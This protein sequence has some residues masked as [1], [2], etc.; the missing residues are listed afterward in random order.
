MPEWVDWQ[1]LSQQHKYIQEGDATVCMVCGNDM[2][3]H[4]FSR[5]NPKPLLD[6]VEQ[7]ADDYNKRLLE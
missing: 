3:H 6:E 7:I 5:V 1:H 2:N 4:W